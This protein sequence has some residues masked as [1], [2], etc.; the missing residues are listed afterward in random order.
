L[1]LELNGLTVEGAA[2]YP[3][4]ALL[5]VDR[6][7]VGIRVVSLLRRKWYLSSV[8]IDRPIAWVF[9]DDHGVS[10]IPIF[11]SSSKTEGNTNVFDLAIRHAELDG[12]EVYYN[13]RKSALAADLHDLEFRSAF[14]PLLQEYSGRVAYSDGHFIYGSLMPIPHSL[15][16]EFSATPATFHLTHLTLSSGPSQVSM[17]ATVQNYSSPIVDAYYD[18]TINGAQAGQILR[19]SSIPAGQLRATGHAQYTRTANA[20]LLKELA[21]NGG[22]NSREL[23]IET[24]SRHV[25][26]TDIAAHYSLNNGDATLHDLQL[27]LLGG[28]L[29]G[30]GTMSNIGGDSHAKMTA[31]LQGISLAALSNLATPSSTQSVTLNGVLNAQFDASWGSNLNTLVAHANTAIHGTLAPVS[32]QT[33]NSATAK[34]G[35]TV[36]ID[37]AIHGTYTAGNQ[38]LALHQS[39]LRT[40]E[41]SLTM[42]GVVSTRSSLDVKLQA[43]DLREVEAAADL[44]RTPAAGPGIA[45][46]RSLGNGVV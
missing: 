22:L 34:T 13:N 10:N 2:P 41:T 42:D 9:V 16:A 23:D 44:F 20:S 18:A 26:A 24:S 43:D 15:E 28:R 32:P 17:T 21:V 45:A 33:S 14:N 29:S 35:T 30:S 25:R 39:Y 38:Q 19:N 3:R 7:D 8:R 27:H 4:P 12:G 6:I 5:W 36:P 1:S 46:A 37:G 40:S 31:A 11:K